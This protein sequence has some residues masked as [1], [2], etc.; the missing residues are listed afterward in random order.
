MPLMVGMG[1]G[2]GSARIALPALSPHARGLSPVHACMHRAIN[3]YTGI[4]DR[5]KWLYDLHL[6]TQR[7]D[8]GQWQQLQ[9]VCMQRRLNGICVTGIDAAASVFG[10]A[11][12]APAMQAL[13][14]GRAG[15]PLD[16]ARL[17]DWEYMEGRNLA[18]LPSLRL[19]WLWQRMFPSKA[20]LQ[21]L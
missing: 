15:E 4:G 10:D 9:D 19:R 1:L 6:L 2:C 20:C 8:D 21:E 16:A 17:H 5:L 12:P 18:A 3:V 11:A 13:R 14:A 7:L